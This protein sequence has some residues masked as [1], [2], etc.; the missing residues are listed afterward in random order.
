MS[1]EVGEV[2]DSDD[3]ALQLPGVRQVRYV[4]AVL[5]AL[6]GAA[7]LLVAT[8]TPAPPLTS[9]VSHSSGS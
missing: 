9:P 4:C 8:L 1:G 2:V 7:E 5:N 3:Q 6:L